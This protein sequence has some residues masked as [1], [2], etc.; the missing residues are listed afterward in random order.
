[1]GKKSKTNV[2]K[3]LPNNN[4]KEK[5]ADTIPSKQEQQQATAA[6]STK[7]KN[8]NSSYFS[9][10]FVPVL[11]LI[12]C[13]VYFVKKTVLEGPEVSKILGK[14]SLLDS[15][16]RSKLGLIA[17]VAVLCIF[18][19]SEFPDTINRR[20]S[21]IFWRIVLLSGVIYLCG[22]V[23]LSFHTVDEARQYMT[24]FDEK[25]GKP[26][27]ERSYAA[28]CRV[29]T[30][31]DPVSKYR[32]IRDAII[33]EFFLGH[34]L[35]WY[36]KSML[37][38]DTWL[39][40]FCSGLFETMELTF[41]HILPNF[42]E[43]WWDSIVLDLIITNTIGIL[44]GK[45]TLKLLGLKE[46]NWIGY[47]KGQP[48]YRW[49]LFESPLRFIRFMFLLVM[50]EVVELCV[51]TMKAHLWIP[52]PHFLVITRLFIVA[53]I[54]AA[55]LNEY[56]EYITNKNYYRW[57]PHSWV[58]IG[59]IFFEVL[60]TVKWWIDVDLPP[61]PAPVKYT[62]FTVGAIIFAFFFTYFPIRH[63]CLASEKSSKKVK[64]E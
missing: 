25:L 49:T 56:H 59:I 54:V 34:A 55:A 46:Y 51:F 38:R 24:I 13:G 48:W 4:N 52:P 63:F 9:Y 31:E 7:N 58:C 42:Y 41:R 40:F 35:G 44:F 60:L 5:V 27:P 30:P 37:F 12:L 17:V 64:K 10:F 21:P 39:S 43:C 15:A 14:E 33:D 6:T 20:P 19:I 45:L 61:F 57:G 2:E 16:A 22:L 36:V 3:T 29:F 23:F 1:M 32:N 53:F 62:W 28:D 8:K 18:A 26:L 11:A 47:K 50:T